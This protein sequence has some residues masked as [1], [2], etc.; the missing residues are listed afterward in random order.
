MRTREIEETNNKPSQCHIHNAIYPY[1]SFS[2]FSSQLPT[3]L[4]L[5]HSHSLSPHSLHSHLI[6][7]THT[8]LTPIHTHSHPIHT[9][10]TRH[11]RLTYICPPL[12][13]DLSLMQDTGYIS[14]EVLERVFC[15]LSYPALCKVS[16]VFISLPNLPPLLILSSLYLA[17][18]PLPPYIFSFFVL[19]SLLIISW[20][21][22]TIQ[23]VCCAWRDL[24]LHPNFWSTFAPD[25]Y[26]NITLPHLSCSGVDDVDDVDDVND[27]FDMRAVLRLPRFAQL[28]SL[29][30]T[31][32]KDNVEDEWLVANLGHLHNLRHLSLYD[33]SKVKFE[34]P[35]LAS[36]LHHLMSLNLGTLAMGQLVSDHSLAVVRQLTNLRRVDLHY[37]EKVSP[38]ESGLKEG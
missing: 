30:L 12:F 20:S 21:E 15:Y 11:S 13:L 28:H 38:R 22:L 2:P 25:A 9:P 4:A 10:F 23:Q 34:H 19:F 29:D 31:P 35:D 3:H 37:C 6:H 5:T 36:R 32:W 24:A 27:T 1:Y 18:L 17:H 8:S 26:A 7:L 33:C 16:Q 14:P